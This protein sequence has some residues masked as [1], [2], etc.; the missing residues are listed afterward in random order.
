MKAVLS[1][2]NMSS[3]S[4]SVQIQ[5]YWA[6]WTCGSAAQIVIWS[7]NFT[8]THFYS[9]GCC[10][11][12]AR[13]ISDYGSEEAAGKRC[14]CV[15]PQLVVDPVTV[16]EQVSGVR[17]R[18][19]TR[20]PSLGLET[21]V[22]CE[23]QVSS[24]SHQSDSDGRT[25]CYIQQTVASAQPKVRWNIWHFLLFYIR[26]HLVSLRLFL[27]VRLWKTTCNSSLLK[28]FLRLSDILFEYQQRYTSLQTSDWQTKRTT[29]LASGTSVAHFNQNTS[30]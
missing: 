21:R 23:E 15:H 1:K 28:P 11:W 26:M 18:W 27:K 22:W 6:T 29:P 25:V 2:I 24:W 30:S 13:V 7:V 12:G 10:C 19:D 14:I 4:I 17:R 3:N 9:S 5:I 20:R 8:H 16:P